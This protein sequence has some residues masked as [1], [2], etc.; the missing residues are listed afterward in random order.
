LLAT[1]VFVWLVTFV[2]VLPQPAL[3]A[4]RHPAA[5]ISAAG[6]K[7]WILLRSCP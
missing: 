5:I 6:P 3:D 7:V 1:L 4:S 2:V